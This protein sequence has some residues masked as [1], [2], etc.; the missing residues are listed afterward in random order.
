VEVALS[1]YTAEGLP[2]I[3]TPHGSFALGAFQPSSLIRHSFR[4]Y[5]DFF[6]LEQRHLWQEK[7]HTLPEL[8]VLNQRD[9]GGSAVFAI[10]RLITYA[11]R[12]YP[13]ERSSVF[14]PEVLYSAIGNNKNVGASMSEAVLAVEER[15]G[16]G[17]TFTRL[18]NFDEIGSALSQYGPVAFS[19]LVGDNFALLEKDNVA[20]HPIQGLG[21]LGMLAVGLRHS[22][23]FWQVKTEVFFGEKFRYIY[24][25]EGYFH[26]L[27]EAF[28]L[29]E[30]VFASPPA[31][32]PS[33]VNTEQQPSMPM[34]ETSAVVT[35]QQPP[36]QRQVA[37]VS[38]P[39][40]I[41]EH[42][43]KVANFQ[44]NKPMV[45]PER[46]RRRGRRPAVTT[47]PPEPAS[48]TSTSTTTTPAPVKPAPKPKPAP[49]SLAKPR[50]RR[51]AATPKPPTAATNDTEIE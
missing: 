18:R 37:P 19:T 30:P 17:S 22:G 4:L 13:P 50:A 42:Q 39:E 11:Q 10:T 38:L 34:P 41:K 26:R 14:A 3:D 9:S 25:E 29:G 31:P 32:A 27:I 44:E 21:G 8:P 36:I 6:P 48:P 20:P 28:M 49:K 15:G 51:P 5:A 24:L 43:E 40:L 1:K 23:Q 7:D 46:V 2:R 35:E 12:K 16:C 47:P 45:D 33:A